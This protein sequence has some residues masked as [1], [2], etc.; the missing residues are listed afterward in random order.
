MKRQH[1][2]VRR[3]PV[4]PGP[5]AWNAILPSQSE[6]PVFEGT[7]TADWVVVGGGFA[8]MAAARRLSQLVGSEA[9]IIV[10]EASRLAHG[11]AGRN[12]G[13]MIDLPHELNSDSY[14]GAKE[15]DLTQIRLN[16]ESIAF[17][18]AMAHEFGMDRA[19]FDE[20][21]KYTAAATD[22]GS[23]HLKTYR[24]HL[25]TLGE[26][27]RFCS[28]DEMKSVTGS[29]FYREGLYTPG[30][31][32]IQPAEFIRK[33]A[34]GLSPRVE[35]FEH[36]PV[37]SMDLKQRVLNTPKGQV[38]AGGVILAVNGHIQSFGFYPRQ[39]LHVFTYASMTRALSREELQRLGGL[40][41]WGI[42]PADPLGTTVRKISDYRGSG[43]RLI[44]R[45]HAT[46]NQT[47]EATGQNMK[48]AA[49]LQ[50]VS[51]ANRFPML[52]GVEMEYRWGGRLCLSWN[53][54]PAVGEVENRIWSAC[55]QNGLGT[56]KGT[57]SGMVA[58]EL[59]VTGQV[60]GDLNDF[61]NQPAPKKL[62]PE[63]FLSL[64]AN[65]TMRM[66]EAK[67]KIEL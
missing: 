64:G 34:E 58:A 50:D 17:A 8:G 37:V 60:R 11:P 46:L 48:R 28:A 3:L 26:A 20:C 21:G 13:F 6:Y 22:K 7:Q 38:T 41:D 67:A 56:I 10:L 32:M 43:D 66:K 5:A 33:T 27:Y 39:L 35:I 51:F 19:V 44:I 1:I 24:Q 31:V 25:D 30:T 47:L 53:S 65:F 36:S 15:H 12:S 2:D 40:A 55:C 45:N 18:K 9:R 49:R 59:A 16:R 57:L 63:P 61:I 29:R 4:D 52:K 42:L 23:E 14:S 54:V 62:P